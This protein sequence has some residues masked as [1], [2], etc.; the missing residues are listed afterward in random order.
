MYKSG[1]I[2]DRM[3]VEKDHLSVIK[4][5][6][7]ALTE[8]G[9]VVKRATGDWCMQKKSMTNMVEL[10]NE[11]LVTLH[12][13]YR[14]HT[15]ISIGTL[16]ET[17]DILLGLNPGFAPE[18]IKFYRKL[19][20]EHAGFLPY[21][22]G[23]RIKEQWDHVVEL[24]RH[25]P[26]SRQASLIIQRPKDRKSIHDP[27][28]W[29]YHFQLNAYGEL[30]LLAFMRSQDLLFGLPFDLFS[31]SIILEEMCIETG[32]PIG[33]HYEFVANL[34]YYQPD[35]KKLERIDKAKA[36]L[37]RRRILTPIK[38]DEI[39]EQLLAI[40]EWPKLRYLELSEIKSFLCKFGPFWRD[41]EPFWGDYVKLIEGKL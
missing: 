40:K 12:P 21:T 8:R 37:G 14:W 32:L 4:Q 30:D 15:L 10:H 18:V 26:T 33:Q 31:Q 36:V 19:S 7:K 13:E 34:H 5:V 2:G 9:V 28:T 11:L 25:R 1:H 39:L 41:F 29:G 20:S 3:I 23:E 16:V 6:K 22:Y 17:L 27:C 35:E 38:R 24:L